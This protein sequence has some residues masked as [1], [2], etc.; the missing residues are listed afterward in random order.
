ML[1]DNAALIE[2]L[3]KLGPE[4]KRSG[5]AQAR[6]AETLLAR[7]DLMAI[8]RHLALVNREL[9]SDLI[10]VMNASGDCVA[11]SNYDS[12]VPLVGGHFADREYFQHTQSGAKGRQYAMGRVTNVPGLFFSAP[13]TARGQLVGA[14]AVKIDVPKPRTGSIGRMHSRPR[15]RRNPGARQKPEMRSTARRSSVK[16]RRP[17]GQIQT[18]RFQ[19]DAICPADDLGHPDLVRMDDQ[20]CRPSWHGGQATTSRYTWCRG[21]MRAPKFFA[22]HKW[23]SCCSRFPAPRDTAAAGGG[24]CR[25][26]QHRRSMEEANAALSALNAQLDRA[27]VN[28]C[29]DGRQ[30]ARASEK[31]RHEMA[32]AT[33][34]AGTL[35][36]IALDLDHSRPSMTPTVMLRATRRS[37]ISPR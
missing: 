12:N 7:E 36:V 35:S 20:R 5:L 15:R 9:G 37:G 22:T 2:M 1:A 24:I 18:A 16:R 10:F 3:A 4:A 31:L 32:R 27:G 25:A 14:I 23:C 17:G 6:L 30:S 19:A 13:V 11:A 28:R 21:S 26:S 34:Y 29:S 33:R 8:N